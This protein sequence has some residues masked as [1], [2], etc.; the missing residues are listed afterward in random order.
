MSLSY[1]LRDA[2]GRADG[3]FS[4][5]QQ[6]EYGAIKGAPVR[7]VDVVRIG[8]DYVDVL[9]R[10]PRYRAWTKVSDLN[11]GGELSFIT[12]FHEDHHVPPVL[13]HLQQNQEGLEIHGRERGGRSLERSLARSGNVLLAC[14]RVHE[15]ENQVEE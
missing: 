11:G 6:K 1:N 13:P 12:N 5:E 7:V 15:N 4:E 10:V 8:R 3:I 14:H 9:D 2:R